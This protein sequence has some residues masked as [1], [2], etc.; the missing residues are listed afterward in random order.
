MHRESRPCCDKHTLFS[1]SAVAF[2]TPSAQRD[3]LGSCVFLHIW[4][5]S[6]L[7]QRTID[8]TAQG[9]SLGRSCVRNHSSTME[10][11]AIASTGGGFSGMQQLAETMDLNTHHFL[12]LLYVL[13][14]TRNSSTADLIAVLLSL[15]E[16]YTSNIHFQ[17]E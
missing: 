8:A 14:Q 4:E 6:Q 2:H 9:V 7:R 16:S 11:N 13:L 1:S 5:Q 15:V 3:C 12:T 10:W 17:K